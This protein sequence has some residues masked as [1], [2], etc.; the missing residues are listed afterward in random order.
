MLPYIFFVYGKNVKGMG[1]VHNGSAFFIGEGTAMNP[2]VDGAYIEVVHLNALPGN[3]EP[4]GPV[5]EHGNSLVIQSCLL[6][7]V[8]LDEGGWGKEM[9]TGKE[10]LKL[11]F[12][13]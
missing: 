11:L 13:C 9:G 6:K 5:F 7:D 12:G 8:F 3:T 2:I 1:L 10:Y 4:H